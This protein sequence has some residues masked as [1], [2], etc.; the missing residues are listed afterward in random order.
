MVTNQWAQ[1]VRQQLGLG[2]LLPLGSSLDCAWIA[3]HAAVRLLRD[4]ADTVLGI[5]VGKIRLRLADTEHTLPT[6]AIPAPP[7]ALPPGPLLIDVECVA[8]G[9]QPLPHLADQLRVALLQ[10]SESRLGLVVTG[11]D[12]RVTGLLGDEPPERRAPKPGRPPSTGDAG[13]D[14]VTRA[15]LAVPGVAR[16]APGLGPLGRPVSST[17]GHLLVQVAVSATRRTLD[18]VRAVREAAASASAER[19]TVAVLVIDVE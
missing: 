10:A 1:V 9:V 19:V 18:V 15:V 8:S 11:A 5:R 3:E 17:D 6:P 14:P 2:R 13:A 4:S 12:V 16:L 7:S